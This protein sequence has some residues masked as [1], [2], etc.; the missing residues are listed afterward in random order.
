VKR[1]AA[2]VIAGLL[3]VACAAGSDIGPPTSTE[4]TTTSLSEPTTTSTVITSPTSST[5]TA[6]ALCPGCQEPPD[7]P[8][9]KKA[10]G[11]GDWVRTTLSPGTYHTRLFDLPLSFTTDEPLVTLGESVGWMSFSFSYGQHFVDFWGPTPLEG[12]DL[13][14]W[15]QSEADVQERVELLAVEQATL[16]GV[17]ATQIDVSISG[18]VNMAFGPGQSIYGRT[19]LFVME[20]DGRPLLVVLSGFSCAPFPFCRAEDEDANE[21]QFQKHLPRTEQFLATVDF[22]R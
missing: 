5:S 22:D 1:G 2:F 17:P 20:I 4:A 8:Q 7:I 12:I 3:V 15:I 21:Y 10:S 13:G 19:R 6:A 14:A 11:F 9:A 16:F 18:D